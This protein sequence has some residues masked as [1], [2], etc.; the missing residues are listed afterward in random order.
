M[1]NKS[2][3][4]CGILNETYNANFLKEYSPFS[5]LSH[6]ELIQVATSI[7]VINLDKHKVLF[8]INDQIF[9]KQF[10]C[11]WFGSDLLTNFIYLI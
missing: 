4:L 9:F 10:F 8:Q 6:Q 7:G 5:Y 1:L 3:E 11:A 2:N